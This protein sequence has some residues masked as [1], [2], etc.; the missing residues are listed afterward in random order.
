[1]EKRADELLDEYYKYWSENGGKM[2]QE[3]AQACANF[4]QWIMSMG[5]TLSK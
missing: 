4:T 1:M 3:E 2:T 5:Y